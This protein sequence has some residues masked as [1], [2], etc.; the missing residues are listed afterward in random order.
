MR[1]TNRRSRYT[2]KKYS[3]F[4]L[5]FTKDFIVRQGGCPVFYIP[6][7]ANV[8]CT[9]KDASPQELIQSIIEGDP[10]ARGNNMEKLG[11]LMQKLAANPLANNISK[12]QYFDRMMRQYHTFINSVRA[13]IPTERHML[14]ELTHFLDFHMF[15]YIKFYD[16]TYADD[17]DDNYYLEREWRVVGN[18]RFSLTDVETIFIPKFFAQRFRADCPSYYSQLIFI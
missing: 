12:R 1:H 2:R 8:R 18:V 9:D 7:E 4:G 10:E 14:M 6:L 5:S 13:S 15:S 3:S 16:H 17:H 11:R